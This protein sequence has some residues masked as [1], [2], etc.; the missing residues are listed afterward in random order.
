M[1]LSVNFKDLKVVLSLTNAQGQVVTASVPRKAY[2][3]FM[4]IAPEG[5]ANK[6]L[7]YDLA[8]KL[9][10]SRGRASALMERFTPGYKSFCGIALLEGYNG[11][12]TGRERRFRS[13]VDGVANKAMMLTHRPDVAMPSLVEPAP[14]NDDF[15]VFSNDVGNDDDSEVATSVVID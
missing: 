15:N 14:A 2:D 7:Q 1:S 11:G 12:E 8:E 10:C 3:V 6:E 5:I 4:S 9:G 13:A